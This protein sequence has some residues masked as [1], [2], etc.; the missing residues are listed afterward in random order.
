MNFFRV[1]RLAAIISILICSIAGSR[2]DSIVMFNEIMYHPLTNE[3][4][5]E[6]VELYNQLAVDVDVSNWVITNGIEYKFPEGTII[7]GGGYI[8]VAKS[9]QTIKTIMGLTNV[10][11]PFEG[12]LAN[13]G[14]TI[15]LRNNNQRLMDV[16]NYG[17]GGDWTVS[18]DG[19]GP[20]LSKLESDMASDEPESWQQS[21]QFGGTPG[22]PN[23]P[24]RKITVS[25]TNVVNANSIW[26]YYSGAI[27]GDWKNINYDDSS[28]GVGAGLFGR[29]VNPPGELLPI[30]GLFN[31]GLDTNGAAL[32][33]GLSDG[34]YYLTASVYSSPPPPAIPAVIT[35]NHPN[36]I[37]NDFVSRWIGPISQGLTSVQYGNYNYRTYFDLTGFNPSTA[38][39][40]FQVAVDNDLTNV[41]LNGSLRGISFSG[42]SAWSS[43]F[44]ITN[45]FQSGTN[46]L[47]FYTYNSGTTP[48]PAGLRIKISGSAMK[49]I[50]INTAL[51]SGQCYY[52]RQIFVYNG[53][54]SNTRVLLRVAVDDGAVFYLN[55]AEVYRFNMPTGTISNSTYAVTNVVNSG[56]TGW[57]EIDSRYLTS[58][59]NIVAAELHQA[60]G[61]SVDGLLGAEISFVSIN[62]PSPL[63]PALSFNEISSVTNGQF[64]IEILNYGNTPVNLENYVLA[65]FGT[66]YCEY[67]IPSTVLQPGEF[68]VFDRSL[69]GFGADPGDKVVLY[70]PNK[71]SVLDSL[72]AKRYPQARYPDGIGRWLNPSELTP[73]ESN[74]FVFNQD[75]VINE[76]MYHPPDI[77]AQ[78]AI[79]YTNK[80]VSFT[81]FW[82]YYQTGNEPALDWFSIEY[83]DSEWQTGKSVFYANIST[84]PAPKGTMLAISN[85][86]QPVITYYF[87]TP[88]IFTNV[89]ED[90]SVRMNIIIDDGAVFYLNGKEIY[91]YGM[92]NGEIG[93]TTLAST[94]IG[95]PAITG[96]ITLSADDLITGTNILAVEVHQYLPPPGSKDVAFAV[97]LTASGFVSP[98]L[99]Y[100][101]S[102][103][104]WIE[105]YNKGNEPVD[106]DGWEI[107]GTTKYGFTTKQIILPGGYLVVAYDVDLIKS[108]YPNISVFGPL[109][110]K[111]S[112]KEGT[113]V[114][115]DSNGNPADEVRY[116]DK[117]SEYADGMGSTIELQNPRA[118]NSKIE[119]W[120]PSDESGKSLWTTVTYR[121][122]AAKEPANCPTYWN[123][124]V[125]G[126][127]DAG[128]VWLDDISVIEYPSGN[129]R[130][131][132][133]NG[134]FETGMNKWRII[135]THRH[136]EVIPEPGNPSNHILH[137]IA[138]GLTEHMHN[139]AETTLAYGASIVNGTEYEISY[140]VKWIGGCN[141]LNTRLYFNRLAKTTELPMT[142]K[143]GTPGRQNTAFVTNTGP[144]FANLKHFPVVPYS[145]NSVVVSVELSDE[146]GVAKAV[147]KYSVNGSGWQVKSMSITNIINNYGYTLV[148]TA[149]IP[150]QSAGNTVQLY[151][152]ALDNVGAIAA[153]PSGGANSRAIYKV[154]D[155]QSLMSKLHP[156]RIIMTPSDAEFLHNATNLMSDE[157]LPCTVIVD[158]KNVFYNA[159]VRMKGSERNRVGFTVKFSAGS[160]LW[161]VHNGFTIDRSGGQSGLGGKHDEILIWR[162]INKAG[163]L[164]DVYDDLCQVFSPRGSEDGSGYLRLAK[165]GD[166][167]LDST[168]K[169][170]GDG[171]MYKLELIYYPT[172][173]VDGNPESLKVPLP[174]LV[175]G[176]DIGDLGDD[177]ENYRWTFLKENHLMRDNYDPMIGLGKAFSLSG[178]NLE[179]QIRQVM[180]VDEWARA[181][182]LLSLIGS[183]DMYTYGNSHNL[184][185]Y[186]RPED[187]R[188]M[189]FLW[190]LDYSFVASVNKAFPG[191]GSANTYKIITTIPDVYRRYYHHLYDLTS[192]TGDSAFMTD[193]AN[194][195]A[196]LLA[197]NWS[198]VVNYLVQRANFVRSY[199]PL[200]A[201][202]AI[203]TNSGGFVA[204]SN[205]ITLSGTAPISVERLEVNGLQQPVVWTSM[206]NWKITVPVSSYT[207]QIIIRA[208][209]SDG[210][211]IDNGVTSIVV[212][213]TNQVQLM[214]V[215]INEWM[216]DNMGPYGYSDSIDGQFQ[217]WFELYNP[218]DVQIDLSNYLLTD[219]LLI[220]DKFVIPSNTVILAKGFLLVWADEEVFQNNLGVDDDIHVNF[221][222]SKDSDSVALF[223]PNGILQHSVSFGA[224]YQNVS[225]G[226]FP[227]GNTNS[228]YFMT[229]WTPKIVN[230]LDLP[231]PAMFISSL[232]NGN[233]K[234]TIIGQPDRSYV[235]EYSEKPWMIQWIPI[236]TNKSQ[237]GFIYFYDSAKESQMKFYRSFMLQ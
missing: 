135:G 25:T 91:R 193:W 94:N 141:K 2:A 42:F 106:L 117:S 180:D 125:M 223:A 27:E 195:Y 145:S 49:N 39:I 60:P 137:L 165:Y 92:P 126:L 87:R 171:E 12:R 184:V 93:D 182:A 221:K 70:T 213:N 185:I 228:F 58:G 66:Y 128:E 3:S 80:L 24:E 89:Q 105:L 29:N 158:E 157:L 26:K 198:G 34:N 120:K 174:D 114:L 28:W 56:F 208:L 159:G 164:P 8:V 62:Y 82:K 176:T 83:D 5:L 175:L 218:N 1:H 204:T 115:K 179:Y 153:Y 172:N 162:V 160:K 74:K 235:L 155:G 230:R 112:K 55:G 38:Q 227:D 11:G 122:I 121:G 192:I 237:N 17:V 85:G 148:A 232:I 44:N 206:T 222:L 51:S 4:E 7:S 205:T 68:I 181:V 109:E 37:G 46:Y 76:I 90:A 151:I 234:I 119:V 190:D 152:E 134:T 6:W 133:Q 75:I 186:F 197:E 154:N 18:P 107:D 129:R 163:G 100:R 183:D 226:L 188:G 52:F 88:F 200:T 35:A 207:N 86:T 203:I 9:P 219:N 14:E 103:E 64:C 147:L 111:L 63:P 84:L 168:F 41:S 170:G 169:N 67:S 156:V 31:T 57:I 140:R 215:V 73:G 110:K 95:V 224:Q 33:P 108:K 131:L 54:P 138:T 40:T 216:A 127:L 69:L 32:A 167:F 161:G 210:N 209:G 21:E 15:E 118:D 22:K 123:E 99:P 77:P 144:T 96:P 45:G 16:V 236:E 48:S 166:V 61:G 212:T 98:P 23:F 191:N 43:S 20:S 150:P 146:D 19:C 79:Y 81:N 72:L 199:L 116:Y 220:P 130:Q 139:H 177:K 211:P 196:G 231:Q 214:S 113:I 189:A 132:I 149:T 65:R 53:E 173:T 229:N 13:D 102:T 202:F 104:Y 50:P 142:D 47:D 217:D 78:P 97:E 178:T 10:Y 143:Y 124:F 71:N 101:A 59:S 225:Q 187:N 136:S 36:W 201:N 194:R 233:V 30:P